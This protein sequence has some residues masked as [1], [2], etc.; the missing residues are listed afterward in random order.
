MPFSSEGD[1][2]W[3]G[4]WPLNGWQNA[5]IAGA[6]FLLMLH[7]AVTADRAPSSLFGTRIHQ[8]FL[9]VVKRRAAQGL[10]LRP[11]K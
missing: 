8:A 6:L 2:F 11:K 10:L 4:Q 3:A 5:A 9:E 1:V 7:R